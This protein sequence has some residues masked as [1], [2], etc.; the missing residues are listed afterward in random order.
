MRSEPG[1]AWRR[2]DG[3]RHR[4]C[5]VAISIGVLAGCGQA[6][7]SDETTLSSLTYAAVPG[8]DAPE[9]AHLGPYRVGVRSLDFTYE[10]QPDVSLMGHISGSTTTWT[11][12][13]GVDVLY[14][15]DVP[16]TQ[17]ADAIYTGG[18]HTGF[19][20]IEGLPETFEI[21]GIAV[22][23]APVLEGTTYPLVVVSHGL[24]NTPG[25][26]SG[27]TENLASKGYIVAAI[28][29]R[30]AQDDPATAAHLFARVMLNRVPDQRR[31]V[32]EMMAL[33]RDPD[34]DL[35]KV[36]DT[37]AI[38]LVGFSMG[39]YGVLGHAG[40]GYDAEG[41]A[42]D[43]VPA[44]A[45]LD[46]TEDHPAYANL[47]RSHLDAVIAFAPWGGKHGEIWSDRA[48]GNVQTPLL[49]LAGS[50]DD[51]SDFDHGITRIF[52]KAQGADRYMLVF[53]NAQHNL[54]QVPAPPSAHLD[55]RSWMTFEDATWRRERLLNVGVHFSTAF[56][57]WK[58]KGVAQRA[59]YLDVPT[60]K[61]NDASWEPSITADYSDQFANGSDG[62]ENYW[63]GFKARQAIGLELHR[64]TRESASLSNAAP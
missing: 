59:D 13:L 29:H 28:D 7:T 22:R 61:S 38:G 19:T 40:A 54:V 14:P 35:G 25:V 47:D 36:I 58:L 23:N 45:I 42:L 60:V 55:V 17:S 6:E 44:A 39:G 46:Q 18:Y 8:D 63:R 31:V 32:S 51:V 48:L 15:A 57:D 34:S 12:R 20:D 1:I 41:T 50:E 10:D 37:S 33:A 52:E 24:L 5:L 30:D 64:R 62:S 21:Q 49:I 53:Q 27:L 4:L 26:L 11:R 2:T 16:A 3:W 56:L 9:L 43:I